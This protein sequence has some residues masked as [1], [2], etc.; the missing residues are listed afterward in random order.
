MDS[1]TLQNALRFWG[2][3]RFGDRSGLGRFGMGLPNSS[4]SQAK[5]LEVYSWQTPARVLQAYLDVEEVASGKMA[6]IPLPEPRA[7]PEWAHASSRRTGTLVVWTDCDRLASARASA[8]VDKLRLSLGRIY[9]RF[10]WQG[11]EIRVNDQ[12]VAPSDP[13]FVDSRALIHGAR[14]YGSALRYPRR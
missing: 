8:V 3:D 14:P 10:I 5:R 6:D 7:L 2:T 12:V 4:V 1:R 9:R 13:L 11:I